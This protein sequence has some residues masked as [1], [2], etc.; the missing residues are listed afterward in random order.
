MKLLLK[1]L[2]NQI[3]QTNIK[4][5]RLSYRGSGNY[6]IL[7]GRIEKGLTTEHFIRYNRLKQLIKLMLFPTEKYL[8]LN[9]KNKTTITT[10]T[11]KKRLI[12]DG[13][14]VLFVKNV[15]YLHGKLKMH[16][17]NYIISIVNRMTIGLRI[18]KYYVP[19]A[20]Q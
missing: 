8:I 19:I 6:K 10:D 16:R 12:R 3:L 1:P 18:S 5:L 15:E 2:K 13:L 4:N 11:L 7:R 14:K 17:S 9:P 20:I